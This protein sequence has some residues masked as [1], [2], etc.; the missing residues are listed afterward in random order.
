MSDLYLV[1]RSRLESLPEWVFIDSAV[2]RSAR[3]SEGFS[4]ETMG[5]EINVSGKTYERYEKGGRVPRS[6]VRK[7]ATVLKLEIEEPAQRRVL[8]EPEEIRIAALEDL[9][10]H[11]DRRLDETDRKLE[12][13]LELA[14][15]QAATRA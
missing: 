9:R 15:A 3:E 8:V 5:R 14:R 1:L 11:L 10:D 12:A 13:L 7:L 2:L 6:L 4:Y